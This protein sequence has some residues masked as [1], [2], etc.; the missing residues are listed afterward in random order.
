MKVL[1]TTIVASMM[2]L[3]SIATAY[4]NESNDQPILKSLA[5]FPMQIGTWKGEKSKFDDA[6]YKVLGVDDSLYVHFYN[7]R[8]Q[9]IEL[10]IG[11]YQ[12][13][14]RGELIHS[15]KNCMPGAGWNIA[16]IEPQKLDINN[17]RGN[18]IKVNKVVLKKGAQTQMMF[19]WFQSRNRVIT[20]EYAQKIFLVWDSITK[21][22]TDESF[23]RLIS[24]VHDEQQATRMLTQ[25][26]EQI[27]PIL[28]QYISN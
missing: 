8:K 26:S 21:H 17:H 28:N 14:R 2:L 5:D 20:S 25:F 22:R 23:V 16:S 12:S 11:Y 18:P 9:T 6:I 27:F 7:Q 24:P 10:Y 15:P 13:Q 1:Q 19:Y 3:T 4:F